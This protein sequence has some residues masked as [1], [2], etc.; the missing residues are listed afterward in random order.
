[1]RLSAKWACDYFHD[2]YNHGDVSLVPSRGIYQRTTRADTQEA[3][4]GQ[5]F[6]RYLLVAPAHAALREL[7]LSQTAETA[8]E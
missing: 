8:T 2:C 6:A 7:M 3:A 5:D 1:V 4:P